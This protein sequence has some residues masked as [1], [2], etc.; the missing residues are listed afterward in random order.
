MIGSMS[1][2]FAYFL[3]F[4]TLTRLSTH[5]LEGILFFCLPVGLARGCCSYASWSGLR[6]SCCRTPGGTAFRDQI[7]C[8]LSALCA[9][10]A[11]M[12]G[13]V[14]HIVWDAFTHASTRRPMP[15]RC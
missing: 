11:V 4:E 14:T 8:P 15:S 13:A 6:S 9:G 1:P 7:P 12:V 10:V 5:S 3:P 2:D